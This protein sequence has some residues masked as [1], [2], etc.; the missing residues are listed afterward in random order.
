[1]NGNAQILEGIKMTIL[2]LVMLVAIYLIHGAAKV[3]GVE[4]CCFL[5]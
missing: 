3:K 1:M 4:D 5:Q 2:V